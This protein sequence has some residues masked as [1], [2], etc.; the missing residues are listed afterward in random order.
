ME[1][2]VKRTPTGLTLTLTVTACD[3]G[4][5]K[6]DGIP[7]NKKPNYDAVDGWLGATEIAVATINAFYRKVSAA[8][9]GSRRG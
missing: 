7:I 6:L 4:M 3:D 2:T 9:R 1:R 5:I 8:H